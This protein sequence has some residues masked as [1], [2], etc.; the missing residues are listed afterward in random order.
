MRVVLILTQEPDDTELD[1]IVSPGDEVH[2]IA[3]AVTQSRLQW[4]TNAEDQPRADAARLAEVTAAKAP[5]PITSAEERPDAPAQVVEDAIR[6][7]RPDRL[8]V[9]LRPETEAS[10]LESGEL[11]RIP[12]EFEGVP[13]ERH[14]LSKPEPSSRA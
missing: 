10:W 7:Y 3:P 14:V 1:E 5:A 13:I 8:V 4:L 9:V 11:D 6:E 2:V 12:D